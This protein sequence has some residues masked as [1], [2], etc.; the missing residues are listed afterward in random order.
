MPRVGFEPTIPV[1]ERS[2]TVHVSDH[3]ATVIGPSPKLLCWMWHVPAISWKQYYARGIYDAGTSN[4][5]SK[6]DLQVIHQLIIRQ[7][8]RKGKPTAIRSGDPDSATWNQV[9][10]STAAGANAA[11]ILK[12]P[13]SV[14]HVL[15]R[16]F[17]HV[18]WNDSRCR[19]SEASNGNFETHTETQW[20]DK[21]L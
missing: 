3:A 2:K 1:F 13:L 21:Y 15:Q 8:P 9:T 5:I 12:T 11:N 10:H 18:G 14:S 20:Q 19:A 17:G 7:G 4:T 16:G 6:P